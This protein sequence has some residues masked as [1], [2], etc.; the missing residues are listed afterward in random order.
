MT[1]TQIRK[2][3]APALILAA[4]AVIASFLFAVDAFAATQDLRDRG[5]TG[6]TITP[7]PP[8]PP[9]PR[10]PLPTPPPPPPSGGITNVTEGSVNSGGN[11]GGNVTTG[12]ESVSVHVVNVGPTNPP[13]PPPPPPSPSP[14]PTPTQPTCDD[15]TRVGCEQGRTR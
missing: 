4:L 14:S 12:D 7:P 6:R 11:T 5:S 1:K 10:A 9:P 2:F 15:R 13:P 3:A 8:P